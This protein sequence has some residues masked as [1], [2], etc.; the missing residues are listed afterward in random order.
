M[1]AFTVNLNIE[2]YAYGDYPGT[3]QS[4]LNITSNLLDSMAALG[5]LAVALTEVPSS[6]LNV[7]VSAGS[8]RK[9]D[10]TIVSYAGTASQA[11][12][13]AATNYL[14]LSDSGTLTANTTGFPAAFHVRLAVVVAGATTITSVTDARIPWVSGGANGNT[15]Y[16]SLA[17]GTLTDGANVALGTGTGSQIGTAA[18][19][20]LGLW[21][22]VPVV[23]P[24]G[25][26]QAAVGTLATQS[27]TVS[28]GGTA[29][30]TLAAATNTGA[31]T[32]STGGTAG[33][34]FPAIVAG[35]VYAQADMV[36]VQTALASAAAE[37]A[38]QRTLNTVL[39]NTVDSLGVQVNNALADLTS[40]KTL[41]NSLRS[42]MVAV[43]TAK[44]SA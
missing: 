4:R 41:V 15:I 19:Q 29:G 13:T 32:D 11:L 28:T 8:F 37:L 31:I 3:W 16:L 20:K 26:A 34:T 7:K 14:Y 18:A 25:A 43:G 10:G 6:T 27:L 39:I 22:A 5:S 35:A 44:G 23:Q 33:S 38:L 9:S 12:T 1:S 42:A 30:T 36:A 2:T 24:S 40:L 21:G 17:G